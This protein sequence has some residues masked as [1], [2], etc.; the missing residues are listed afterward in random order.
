MKFT[1]TQ[2]P[3]VT[4][5]DEMIAEANLAANRSFCDEADIAGADCPCDWCQAARDEYYAAEAAIECAYEDAGWAEAE[6]QRDYEDR[7]GVVQFEDAFRLA[8]GDEG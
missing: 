6:A 5:L 4:R 8:V 7:M 2:E 3:L 1:A